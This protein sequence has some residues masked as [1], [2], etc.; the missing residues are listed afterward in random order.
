MGDDS[1]DDKAFQEVQRALQGAKEKQAEAAKRTKLLND[2][3]KE[4][5]YRVEQ[6][7]QGEAALRQRRV[8]GELPPPVTLQPLST[9]VRANQGL[10]MA[11]RG[12]NAQDAAQRDADFDMAKRKQQA[13]EKRV[14]QQLEAQALNKQ[15]LDLQRKT[16]E[17][18]AERIPMRR[19][20][21]VRLPRALTRR[22]RR[23]GGQP[24]AAG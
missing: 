19:N 17:L 22:R 16:D 3:A 9:E 12:P 23:Q 8:A 10:A 1:D 20:H 13:A 7:G 15:R 6:L 2:Q 24:V 21:T 11:D 18:E 14:R 4:L 5:N